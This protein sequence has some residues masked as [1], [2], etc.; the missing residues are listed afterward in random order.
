MSSVSING[1][2]N[3]LQRKSI[4]MIQLFT[5]KNCFSFN[6]PCWNLKLSLIITKTAILIQLTMQAVFQSLQASLQCPHHALPQVV[7]RWDES[8]WDGT[9]EFL[10]DKFLHLSHAALGGLEVGG[11][12]ACLQTH[13]LKLELHNLQRKFSIST[14]GFYMYMNI[15]R[16]ILSFSQAFF[17]INNTELKIFGC[18]NRER[19]HLM[20]KRR[21]RKK[22]RNE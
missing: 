7:D 13:V 15:F 20:S 3:S 12:L 9:A 5:A 1:F 18:Q 4:S 19:I 21:L 11:L 17:F 8:L 16:C 14:L 2:S 22:L 6:H 10:K